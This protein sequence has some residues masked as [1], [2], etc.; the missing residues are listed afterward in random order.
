MRKKR[1]RLS[2]IVL[3]L[4]LL[5]TWIPAAGAASSETA[6]L[7]KSGETAGQ[8]DEASSSGGLTYAEYRESGS[9]PDGSAVV[10]VPLDLLDEASTAAVHTD[11]G[12][13]GRDAVVIDD[14]AFASFSFAVPATGW[15]EVE[16]DYM[17]ASAGS[18]DVQQEWEIDGALPFRGTS[19]LSYPR[20]YA[21]N[22]E[23][24]KNMAGNERKPAVEEVFAWNTYAVSDPS[25]Y[26]SG[27]YR[28]LFTQGEHTLTLKGNRGSLAVSAIR[29][30]PPEQTPT[31]EEYVARHEA[32][33]ARRIEGAFEALEAEKIA[34]KS[35][36]TI[37]PDTDK[38]SPATTPQSAANLLLNVIGGDNFQNIG[39]Q[40]GWEIT[41]E[42]SGFYQIGFRFK[43]STADGIFTSR[44]LLVDGEVPFQEADALRFSYDA[45]WQNQWLGGEEAYWIYLEA[46]AHTMALEVTMGDLAEM[47]GGVQAALS[48]MNAIYRRII[49]ITGPSPDRYRD[50]GFEEMIPE[51]LSRMGALAGE[52]QEIVDGFDAA[53]GKGGSYTSIIK[54]IIFQLEAMSGKPRNIAKYLEQ[55]KA[56]LG[57]LGTWLLDAQKQPLQL[58]KVYV[59]S[60]GTALPKAEAGLFRRL[61]FGI[62]NFVYSFMTDYSSIGAS[63]GERY[64][65]TI[66]VWIQTGRD[67]AE[68]LR[69]LIDSDFVSQT[70][71][72]V[73]MEL[74]AAGSL[75]VS[76]LS[77]NAPD[78]C[79]N[80]PITEPINYATRGAAMDLTA[81]DD[82]EEVAA[83]FHESALTPYTF[84]DRTYGLPETFSFYMFF[85]RTDI[86]EELGLKEPQTWQDLLDL[87][88][89]LQSQNLE[90]GIPHDLNA[91]AM[92]LYQNGGELYTEDGAETNIGSNEGLQSFLELTELFTLYDLPPT[93][94]FANRFRSGEM[95]CGI[96]DYTMY[97][98]MIAFAPEIR[99]NWK[100]VPVPGKPDADGNPQ[101]IS[102]GTG[103]AA[104]ILSTSRQPQ[105][106][107]EFLKWYLSSDVQ[108]SF[109]VEMESLLGPA[110]KYATANMEALTRMTWSR[111]EYDSLLTQMDEVMAVPQVPGGYYLQRILTFAFNRVYNSSGEQTMAENPVEVITE[112]IPELNQELARKRQ[113]LLGE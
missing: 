57:S 92:L 64:D 34:Y 35:H 106:S 12:E 22:N 88:A 98:Q 79:L 69:N 78:V 21:Q 102:V 14:D 94:D 29:L 51:E 54:K 23:F 10:E 40:I 93:F 65:D 30:C 46:G 110:A 28:F 108:S 26:V 111:E 15:Y 104:M 9:Y 86:F 19:L 7:A 11:Y 89:E 24:E 80:N 1:S 70:R 103:T 101:R 60:V 67:Q 52:L 4:L 47:I 36:Q 82:F 38:T 71:T 84:R 107:W 43:Q 31:Y 33:G 59:G 2:A 48:E 62:E 73:T 74:V 68:I 53:A 91:Y 61:Q 55:F 6:P 63:G 58:D 25:G 45:A 37:L 97:N 50:Y 87:I 42:E 32:E 100:M 96:Q 20:R 3:S 39:E 90:M 16:I 18:G 44:R 75:L 41:V 77:G 105:K 5:T 83:Y 17:P 76:V 8:P 27:P 81:F 72:N 66:K 109:A 99:G 13:T 112:Y 56:N 95:P 85:Y 49:T 113:E